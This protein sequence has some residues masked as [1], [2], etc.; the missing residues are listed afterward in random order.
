MNIKNLEVG[1]IIKN[2]KQICE[3]LNEDIKTGKSKQLQLKDWERYFSFH[4]EGQKIIIDEV[5]NDIK[6]KVDMRGKQDNNTAKYVENIE[7]NIIGELLTK[8]HESKYVVGRGVLLR[9]VGLTNTNYSYCKRRQ[10]KLASYL[11]IKKELVN[12]YY[13]CIDSM[14]LGNL[15]KALKNLSN[16]KLIQLNSALLICKNVLTNIT[17]QH[18]TE[19]DEFDEEIEI[20]KPIVQ[21][22]VIYI[23]ATDEE[24]HLINIIEKRILIEMGFEKL[25]D[26]FLRNK[27]KEY[28]NKCYKE[29]R[30]EIKDLN[31][32]FQAYDIVYDFDI[33]ANE[34]EKCGYDDWSKELKEQQSNIINN[35]AMDRI[36]SNAEKRKDKATPDI[37]TLL[38]SDKKYIRTQDSYIE[39]YN[40]LNN[41]IINN[42]AKN[43][44]DKIKKIKK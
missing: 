18:I 2:Y 37:G 43:I 5:F 9:N 6:E 15:E 40:Q 29:L 12:D 8:G 34:L 31:F 38:E 32:Y 35:G 41:N 23:Q 42:K 39:G 4:K 27:L 44:K 7:L 33:L 26:V 25:T 21:S 13:N 20:I 3:L 1:Q 28:Y 10:D 24:R 11:E 19:I 16:K 30:K 17:Y 36:I 22:D 14:L